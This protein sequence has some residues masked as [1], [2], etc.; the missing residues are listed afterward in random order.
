MSASL[1]PSFSIFSIFHFPPFCGPSTLLNFL[2]PVSFLAFIPPSYLYSL[3]FCIPSDLT[4][5]EWQQHLICYF[6]S[7]WFV[8]LRMWTL[9]FVFYS[10]SS[11]V[12]GASQGYFGCWIHVDDNLDR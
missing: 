4:C 7:I 5:K 3:S 10:K 2:C 11:L 12:I 8:V 6:S 9:S 1:F